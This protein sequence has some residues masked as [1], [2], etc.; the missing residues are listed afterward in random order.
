MSANHINRTNRAAPVARSSDTTIPAT[1]VDP[2]VTAAWPGA[3]FDHVGVSASHAGRPVGPAQ[4]AATPNALADDATPH[5]DRDGTTDGEDHN[6]F[7]LDRIIADLGRRDDVARTIDEAL[8]LAGAIEAVGI[9]RIV[10][11][12]PC[13]DDLGARLNDLTQR[14]A[15]FAHGGD[16]AAV[17]VHDRV[18]PLVRRMEA[19]AMHAAI[20]QVEEM[21]AG[22][23]PTGAGRPAWPSPG[24]T[25]AF[26]FPA[27]ASPGCEPLGPRLPASYDDL[28]DLP[29]YA[30][31]EPDAFESSGAS[32][33]SDDV[34]IDVAPYVPLDRMLE[35]GPIPLAMLQRLFPRAV[36]GEPLTGPPSDALRA[37]RPHRRSRS[38]SSRTRTSVGT[39]S[40]SI[41]RPPS[42]LRP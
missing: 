9:S 27:S 40:P 10:T 4:D 7:D 34:R 37:V 11:G 42:L 30:D 1:P 39:S 38:F 23:C 2:G 22:A 31:D 14:L 3:T 25:P 35:N 5:R 32:R 18:A 36:R 15:L 33:T 13:E 6:S 26:A 17:M 41:P 21:V 29:W 28:D 24:T 16:A 20:G 19:T 12:T 8:R